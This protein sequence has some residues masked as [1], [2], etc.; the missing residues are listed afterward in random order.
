MLWDCSYNKWNLIVTCYQIPPKKKKIRFLWDFNIWKM[1][2]L[3][4]D[5]VMFYRRWR[6]TRHYKSRLSWVCD[7]YRRFTIPVTW[8]ALHPSCFIQKN[9]QNG[10]SAAG[11][12]E[13]VSVFP[14][15]AQKHWQICHG[16]FTGS[17]LLSWCWT[18]K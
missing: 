15:T 3:N 18:L 16:L 12:W 6:G 9:G 17:T 1:T 7:G 5:Q 10:K 8:A 13:K 11:T 14:P 4:W 2:L